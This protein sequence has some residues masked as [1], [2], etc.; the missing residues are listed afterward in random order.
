MN[1]LDLEVEGSY[2]ARQCN[3]DGTTTISIIDASEGDQVAFD[4]LIE[5]IV[6]GGD[7]LMIERLSDTLVNLSGFIHPDKLVLLFKDIVSL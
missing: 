7:I 3:S 1:I 5:E 4:L 2:L 6:R